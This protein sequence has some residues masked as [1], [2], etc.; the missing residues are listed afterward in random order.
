LHENGSSGAANELLAS[1]AA[2]LAALFARCSK[3]P[4]VQVDDALHIR[5][6]HFTAKNPATKTK[7][8]TAKR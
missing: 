1:A 8:A 3:I 5:P 4:V 6:V 7:P 2:P